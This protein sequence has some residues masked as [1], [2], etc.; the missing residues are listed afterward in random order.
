M[1]RISGL[2]PL[3][4]SSLT[5]EGFHRDYGPGAA[6]GLF[7][8]V[9]WRRRKGVLKP[10]HG[11]TRSW[12]YRFVSPMTGKARWM[13]LGPTDAIG[14]AEARDLA[15]AAR[16]L[17]KLGAD[18]IEHRGA[19]VK[20]ERDAALKDLASRMTFAECASAYQKAHLS[21]FRNTETPG[22]MA[23][24]PRAGQRRFR[25]AQCRR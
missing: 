3:K 5:V 17:V 19:A 25:Q 16:R 10:E 1:A 23:L 18:P 21:T 20:A 8:Q 7:V 11:V 22:P 9:S 24:E 13:G 14:L 12:V 2:T 4:V 6:T 15:R